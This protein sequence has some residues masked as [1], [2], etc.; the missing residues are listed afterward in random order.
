[1]P[2]TNA[3]YTETEDAFDP[4]ISVQVQRKLMQLFMAQLSGDIDKLQFERSWKSGAAMDPGHAV[5]F[6]FAGRTVS[7]RINSD[8]SNQWQSASLHRAF[9]DAIHRVDQR[10]N[11]RWL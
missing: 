5:A 2:A 7:I 10:C 3:G 8:L 1:L 4:E 6:G 9:S 11:I